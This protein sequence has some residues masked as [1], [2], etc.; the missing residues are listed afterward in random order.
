M[1]KVMIEIFHSLILSDMAT[2]Y[3][4]DIVMID[5]GEYPLNP[6]SKKEDPAEAFEPSSQSPLPGHHT[7]KASNLV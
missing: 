1:C 3:I 5:G 6:Y 7:L 4:T 2:K